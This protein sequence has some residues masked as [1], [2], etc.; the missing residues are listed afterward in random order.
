MLRSMFG[1]TLK[2]LL[3]AK[4]LWLV[5]SKENV[6]GADFT[7]DLR[8][9]CPYPSNLLD[10]GAN[11]GQSIKQFSVIW[12]Q[13]KI[14]SVEPDPDNF[15]LLSQ[16]SHPGLVSVANVGFADI[17]GEMTLNR[18]EMNV[19]NSFLPPSNLS[20]SPM[21]SK[22]TVGSVTVPIVR[23]TA[24]RLQ[25][26]FNESN[27]DII[28]IDTQGFDLCVLKS[29]DKD[30]LDSCKLL[31]IEVNFDPMYVGQP[32]VSSIM[33]YCDEVGFKFVSYYEVFRNTRGGISWAT[34]VFVK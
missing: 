10:V 12:P 25:S 34:A 3:R 33:E 9:L 18:F 23:P 8:R 31:L 15:R 11:I 1:P 20:N 17:D 13:V 7:G 22:P 32:S 16:Y 2:S 26:L 28:K 19:L 27:M 24:I 14:Y 6:T 4:G 21:N 30:V 5:E 29:F